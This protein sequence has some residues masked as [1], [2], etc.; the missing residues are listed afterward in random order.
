[1]TAEMCRLRERPLPEVG[2][3]ALVMD[4]G[5][6]DRTVLAGVEANEQLERLLL[7]LLMPCGRT[8]GRAGR[9]GRG[10]RYRLSS[11]ELNPET[12]AEALEWQ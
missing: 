6:D 8:E 4:D 1:M 12:S 5:D 9:S 7:V 3:R 11:R 10:M 2:T